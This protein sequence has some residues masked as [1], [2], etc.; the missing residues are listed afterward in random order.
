MAGLLVLLGFALFV[1]GV[2]ALFKPLPRIWLKSRGMAAVAMVL[3]VGSCVAAGAMMPR[4]TTEPARPEPPSP[5]ADNAPAE[6]TKVR[7]N[8]LVKITAE[9]YRKISSGMTYEQAVEIIGEPGEEISASRVTRSLP[10]WPSGATAASQ[11]PASCG[12]G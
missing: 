10:D 7:T 2:V 8:P 4:V 6:K 11:P 5:I 3:G 12:R 1:L 9:E